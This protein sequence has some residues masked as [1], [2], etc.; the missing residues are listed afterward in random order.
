MKYH[1]PP[2]K[3]AALLL[4]LGRQP[5]ERTLDQLFDAIELEAGT[6]LLTKLA[7]VDRVL[8]DCGI[9]IHPKLQDEPQ[10]GIFLLRQA[11]SDSQ[12]ETALLGQISNLES[13]SQ[14]LKS[15]YWC[16]FKRLSKQSNATS[17][18][19]RSEQV[20]QSALK[21]VAGFLT[22]GGGTL[23]IGV[24]DEGKIL[25]LQADLQILSP[26]RRNVDQ[27][28]NNIKT[29][30]SERFQEGNSIND[31]VKINAM[32][33]KGKQILKLE[34]ASRRKLS[35]IKNSDADYQLFRRQDNRTTEVKIYELEEFQEWR[36]KYVL[37]QSTS[38]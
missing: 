22:T 12:S 31:Y 7:V 14:E 13:G 4:A 29:D 30:I 25:G 21:S 23:F 8:R 37:S 16:D 38:T 10:D 28:I 5:Q 3:F 6:P 17:E 24:D 9:E 34:I 11:K 27:L 36:E 33:I 15:T 35:Y 32:R 18:E 2:A 1:R 19:L 26:K 20:K